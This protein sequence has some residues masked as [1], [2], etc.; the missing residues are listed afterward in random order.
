MKRILVILGATPM[1]ATALSADTTQGV[2]PIVA[3]RIIHTTSDQFAMF[4][5]SITIGDANLG[6]A[7]YRWGGSS[8][9]ALTLPTDLVDKLQRGMN[10]PRVLIEPYTKPGQAGSLCLVGFTLI[11]RS[12]LGALP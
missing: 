2:A 7:Q 1:L 8:C 9:P 11:L 10:N 6:Y 12:D 5:G 3:L 4:R